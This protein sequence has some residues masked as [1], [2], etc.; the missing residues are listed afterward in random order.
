M[1]T[2]TLLEAKDLK[3]MDYDGTSDPYVILQLSKQKIQSSYIKNTLDPVWNET[4]TF[5]VQSRDEILRLVVMDRDPVGTD[6][7]EGKCT[8]PLRDL[9]D[10]MKHDEWFNLEPETPG[11]PWQGR[12]PNKHLTMQIRLE[13][14]WIYSR[15]EY[16]TSYLRRWEETLNNH[17]TQIEAIELH[18]QKLRTPFAWMNTDTIRRFYDDKEDRLQYTHAMPAYGA[19]ARFN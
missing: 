18:L 13:M 9:R 7:F 8:I 1:L 11:T 19:Q 14:Q 10:Q 2:V 16:M 6:D 4:Y 3:P 17:R 12:V 15:V 5:D